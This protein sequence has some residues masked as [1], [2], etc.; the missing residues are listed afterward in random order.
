MQ[1]YGIYLNKQ[2]QTLFTLVLGVTYCGIWCLRLASLQRVCES[3]CQ[4]NQYF[5]LGLGTYL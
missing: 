5:T 1:Q 4:V 3:A 2:R